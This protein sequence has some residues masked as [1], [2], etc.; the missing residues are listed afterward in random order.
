M[1]YIHAKNKRRQ[2]FIKKN[3]KSE[4]DNWGYDPPAIHDLSTIDKPSIRA[5]KNIPEE[6][7]LEIEKSGV[8]LGLDKE[9]GKGYY[10]GKSSKDDGNILIAGINGSGKSYICAKSI[11]ETWREPFVV[12]DCKGEL[13]THYLSLQSEGRVQRKPL[14][15]D[16]LIDNTHYNPFAILQN[17]DIHFEENVCEIAYSLIPQMPKNPNDYWS[18][19]ARDLLAAT[20][21]YGFSIKLDFIETMAIAVKFSG[22]ELC[23]KIN[24]SNIELAKDHI[25]DM[26]GLKEEQLA[27]IG[28]DMKRYIRIFATDPCIQTALSSSENKRTFTWE[29]FSTI[30]ETPNIFLRLSQ[31]RLEQWGSMTRLMITQLIR[32]LE[33]RPD[34]Q[35]FQ[36]QN[37]K[38]VL[39]LLDEFPLLGK[40]DAITNALTTLR[41]KKVTFCLMIQSIAQLDA[42]YGQD[43]RKIIVDNCQYKVLFNIT[44]PDS[45]EYFSRL[46]GSVPIARRGL[47]QSYNPYTDLI[48]YGQQIQEFREPWILPH[49]F[50]TNKDIWIH[51]PYGFLSALKLPV[52]VTHHHV[53][54]FKKKLEQYVRRQYDVQ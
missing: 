28:T 9:Y 39:L 6:M 4:L 3:K 43:I 40:M 53:N 48:T 30:A 7:I 38:P 35:S 32:T 17:D 18:D 27:A 44:E 20:I 26:A 36:R 46:I 12:L 1:K 42:I 34:K 19:M 47:S 24:Q 8:Y 11:I 23:N 22:F 41:S 25:R 52:S 37:T 13:Y 29:D 51:S 31:D 49:E 33:R 2:K 14:L 54:D 45:Q 50:A 15:F 21:I 10:V 5:G 16:P